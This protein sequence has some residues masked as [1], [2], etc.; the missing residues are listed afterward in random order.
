MDNVDESEFVEFIRKEGE[1]YFIGNLQRPIV[2]IELP[3]KF[4]CNG[5]FQVHLHKQNFGQMVFHKLKD[6]RE[7]INSTTTNVIEFLR[8]SVNTDKKEISKG[9]LWVEMKY[10]DQ[11]GELL[12][13]PKEL[14]EWY[15]NLVKY[16][17][18]KLSKVEIESGGNVMVVYISASLLALLNDGYVVR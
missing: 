1:I 15:N 13:K 5:W 8:T 11:K 14:N 12:E 2:I 4:S 6:G 10:Y 7:T 9:R 16:I 3:P 18:N 17:K